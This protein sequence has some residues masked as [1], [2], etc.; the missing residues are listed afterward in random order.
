MD[1]DDWLID[2]WNNR[3]VPFLYSSDWVMLASRMVEASMVMN[4]SGSIMDFV[5]KTY[6]LN[7]IDTVNTEYANLKGDV[8][9]GYVSP[10]VDFLEGITVLYWAG[11]YVDAL[12]TTFEYWADTVVEMAT[13]QLE[14]FG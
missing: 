14:S 8:Y 7:S 4:S 11:T 13:G 6:A 1:Y 3:I 2:N 12:W 5:V 9:D 10:I